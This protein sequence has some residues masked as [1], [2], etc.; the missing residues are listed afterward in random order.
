[1]PA[2]RE[3]ACSRLGITRQY[4]SKRTPIPVATA[5]CRRFCRQQECTEFCKQGRCGTLFGV[6]TDEEIITK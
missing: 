6:Y 5:G 2:N 3:Q 4:V 1:M